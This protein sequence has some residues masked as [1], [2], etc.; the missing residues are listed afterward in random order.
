MSSGPDGSYM[1]LG[2]L[3][4]IPGITAPAGYDAHG[5]PIGVQIQGPHWSEHTLLRV[6]AAVGQ[7]QRRPAVYYD[8]LS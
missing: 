4:G 5:L 1:F 7:P 3:A 6:A 2:N 8:V